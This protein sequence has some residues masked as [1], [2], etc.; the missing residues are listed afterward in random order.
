MNSKAFWPVVPIPPCDDAALASLS[1][2]KAIIKTKAIA[3]TSNPIR[4]KER[5]VDLK[6]L[7][8]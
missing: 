6:V 7:N 2:C 4:L 3:K 1:G 8:C 5:L